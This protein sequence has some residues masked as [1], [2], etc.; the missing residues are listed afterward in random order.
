MKAVKISMGAPGNAMGCLGVSMN[1][2][3]I[4]SG[5]LVEF[6][7]LSGDFNGL[8]TEFSGLPTVRTSTEVQWIPMNSMG[9][10]MDYARIL[11]D[12]QGNAMDPMRISMG[13]LGF[14]WV[15]H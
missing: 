1:S 14:E 13:L 11:T 15:S 10:L 12:S 2:L 9:T 3:G 5:S 4:F 7:G 6:N 8:P